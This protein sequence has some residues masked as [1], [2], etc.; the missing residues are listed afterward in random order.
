MLAGVYTLT[1]DELIDSH[2]SLA[3]WLKVVAERDSAFMDIDLRVFTAEEASAFEG[4]AIAAYKKLVAKFGV[5]IGKACF[6]QAGLAYLAR[7]LRADVPLPGSMPS[8][9]ETL[10]PPSDGRSYDFDDLWK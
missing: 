1:A 8:T 5:E 3:R 6:A 9:T 4:S 7:M 10:A 2:P